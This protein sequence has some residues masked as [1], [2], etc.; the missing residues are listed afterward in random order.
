MPAGSKL[1]RRISHRYTVAVSN[2]NR[3]APE[4]SPVNQRFVRLLPAVLI[5]IAI[6]A[7]AR[8][9]RARNEAQ[10]SPSAAPVEE[11]FVPLFDGQSLAGWEGDD[12][13]WKAE[14]EMIVGDSPGIKQNA[15]LATTKSFG[16]FELRLEFRLRKGE[17]NSGIQ[18]RSQRVAES[19]EVSGYQADIGEK[20]WGCLYDESRR[21]KVLV[22]APAELERALDKGGWN[23]YVIR[24]VGNRIVLSLDGITTVIYRE[25]DPAIA[26]EGIIALQVHAGG[27]LRVEF[28]RLRIK[29]L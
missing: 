3:I 18:F 23:S 11:G 17:G 27:P 8:M 13:L 15:F 24:A 25:N 19:S 2:R 4:R 29:E 7:L 21:N 16:D 26:R 6:A 5:V 20:Y 1:G 9:W 12:K 28:R 22:Q 10:A 14:G